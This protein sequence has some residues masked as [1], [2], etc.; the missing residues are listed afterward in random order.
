M[1]KG[2]LALS[3]AL[4]ALAL[5]P[6]A[7]ADDVVV[8][9]DFAQCP[10]ADTT[11]V[12]VGVELAGPGGR[13]RV[14]EGV[15]SE[16][17]TIDAGNEGVHVVGD[18]VEKV[19]LDGNN[20]LLHGLMLSGTTGVRIEKLTVRRYVASGLSVLE[21]SSNNVVI[22]NE[23]HENVHR[24]IDVLAAGVG[25]HLKDNL[26]SENGIP[27]ASVAAP[28]PGSGI[29]NW[30]TP[31]TL[32]DDN[33]VRLNAGHGV[34]VTGLGSTG[35]TVKDNVV[36]LNG[37]ANDH[38]GIRLA[39]V[40]T[41]GVT[42]GAREPFV[43][44]VVN[45]R[46]ELNRHDGVHLLNAHGNV[47]RD[48]VLIDNGTPGAN[49]GCGNDIENG[50]SNN[51]IRNNDL[52][53]HDRAGIRLRRSPAASLPPTLNLVI[54][55]DL[56]LNVGT[57]PGAG[58]GILLQDADANTFISN[59]SKKNS[60]DGIR[61][62]AIV[63][64]DPV[65]PPAHSEGNTFML[66]EAVENATHDCHDDSVGPVLPAGTANFWI[67]NDGKTQNRIGLCKDAAVVPT[68]HP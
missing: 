48:N 18:S 13:V 50:S 27:P 17:V 11:S 49:N 26:V 52:E 55:N 29:V 60:N 33:V 25:N 66:N 63:S 12:E 53:Q 5:A 8:D 54:E 59:D 65:V 31:G 6:S 67:E 3:A 40:G 21:G 39:D 57:V 35:V 7:L 61:A 28:Y 19:I 47:V 16:S 43:V 4:V 32:I 30:D 23:F 45:N 42:L 68:T 56:R 62:G 41:R 9:N 20:A 64:A 34:V 51:T 46:A 58:Y 1:C 2:L 15:Y 38:D 22:Y 44:D 36:F 10:D 14:C 24:G 37:S